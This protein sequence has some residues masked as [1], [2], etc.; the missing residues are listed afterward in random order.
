MRI[1]YG[2]CYFA[3]SRLGGGRLAL[4]LI[5]FFILRLWDTFSFSHSGNLSSYQ[6]SFSISSSMKF[7][8]EVTASKIQ[9]IK[10]NIEW[11]S[12]NRDY[13]V[14]TGPHKPHFSIKTNYD[15]RATE[16]PAF[17][18]F[19]SVSLR[20]H[21]SFHLIKPQ[22]FPFCLIESTF[23]SVLFFKI[24]TTDPI[25]NI[26]NSKYSIVSLCCI[27]FTFSMCI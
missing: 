23:A 3:R 7:E 9:S 24:S 17:N 16:G 2:I 4:N 27:I 11:F 14:T 21:K 1:W 22:T 20:S 13:K 12:L 18:K 26:I 6:T 5:S 15:L 25:E 10:V 8:N 19:G